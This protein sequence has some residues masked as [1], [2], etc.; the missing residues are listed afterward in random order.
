VGVSAADLPALVE[1]LRQHPEWREHLRAVL[2]SDD[3]LRLPGTVRELAESHRQLAHSMAELASRVESLAM[4]MEELAARVES[5]AMRMEELAAAQGRTEEVL[6]Q[7]ASQV[8][9][10]L[11][12]QRGEAG[13]REGERYE[14]QTLARA[15]RILGAGWGGSPLHDWEVRSWLD[16]ALADLPAPSEEGDPGLADILWRKDGEVA[17]VEVSVAVDEWDVRRARA[18]A[19]TL[20]A[21]GVEAVPMV[22]GQRWVHRD[23]AVLAAELGVE[24]RIGEEG[25]PGYLRFRSGRGGPSH[26]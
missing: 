17:V 16:R 12:W 3:L 15:A 7:L 18:R 20:R 2:L 6:A 8:G 23:V 26:A 14:R 21:A 10:L 4:R 1:L 25:S 22:V 9:S 13:R 11:E 24:W 5:L 19:E